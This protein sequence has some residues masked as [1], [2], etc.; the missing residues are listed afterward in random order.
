VQLARETIQE[1]GVAGAGAMGQVMGR[2]MPKLKGR[3]DGKL[4]NAIVRELLT[5]S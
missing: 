2:L 1:L 3:A 5:E 4:V